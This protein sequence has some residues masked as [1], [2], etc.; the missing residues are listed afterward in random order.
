MERQQE[1]VVNHYSRQA[2]SSGLFAGGFFGLLLGWTATGTEG[3]VARC[4]ELDESLEMD[5]GC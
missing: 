1:E 5:D 4:V 3:S 2:Q